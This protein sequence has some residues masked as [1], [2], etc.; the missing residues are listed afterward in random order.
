MKKH[1]KLTAFI[2][3]LANL[4][5]SAFTAQAQNCNVTMQ[6]LNS[7]NQQVTSIDPCSNNNLELR[8]GNYPPSYNYLGGFEITFPQNLFDITGSFSILFGSNP[9][10]IGISGNNQ[11]ITYTWPN[12]GYVLPTLP[13]TMSFPLTTCCTPTGI[14]NISINFNAVYH[15]PLNPN[16][17]TVNCSINPLTLPV[18]H[19]NLVANVV[20]TGQSGNVFYGG[21]DGMVVYKLINNGTGSINTESIDVTSIM[22][23][24]GNFIGIPTFHFTDTYTTGMPCSSLPPA[25]TPVLNGGLQSVINTSVSNGPLSIT[26]GHPIYF[27][28]CLTANCTNGASGGFDIGFSWGCANAGCTASCLSYIPVVFNYQVINIGTPTLEVTL[29]FTSSFPST[30]AI[31]PPLLYPM[32]ADAD[33]FCSS[34]G[35][36]SVDGKT[37]IAIK[38]KNNSTVYPSYPGVNNLSNLKIYL[39]ITKLWGSIDPNDPVYISDQNGNGYAELPANALQ[40]YT[41]MPTSPSNLS[42]YWELD[43]SSFSD[44]GMTYHNYNATNSLQVLNGDH[45]LDDLKEGDY[46]ILYFT[47]TYNNT[48]SGNGIGS[49]FDYGNFNG[50]IRSYEHFENQCNNLPQTVFDPEHVHY[51]GSA[52]RLG[53]EE[54]DYTMISDV[55]PLNNLTPATAHHL[56]IS[57][58]FA[59]L[60]NNKTYEF[61]CPTPQL[62]IRVDLPFAYHYVL[63]TVQPFTVLLD[64]KSPTS[65]NVPGAPAENI[66]VQVTPTVTEI[67][68]DCLNSI[69]GHLDITF[70]LPAS[71]IN[72][73]AYLMMP[74]PI[75]NNYIDL[76]LTVDCS[77]PCRYHPVPPYSPHFENYH[78]EY[79]FDCGSTCDAG[80]RIDHL[81][82]GDAQTIH[83]CPGDC[84]AAAFNV[85]PDGFTL[86]RNVAGKVNVD[87]PNIPSVQ[88]TSSNIMSGTSPAVTS[89]STTEKS[90][91]YP[92]DLVK[93]TAHTVFGGNPSDYSGT[94]NS[95]FIALMLFHDNV[96]ANYEDAVFSPVGG[97]YTITAHFNSD[98]E[99]SIQ[100]SYSLTQQ[101]YYHSIFPATTSYT[102]STMWSNALTSTL[103]PSAQLNNQDEYFFRVTDPA[104]NYM[105]NYTPPV[106]ETLKYFK[107]DFNIDLRVRYNS[108]SSSSSL[109][110]NYPTGLTHLGPITASLVGQGGAPSNFQ[111]SCDKYLSLFN[112]LRPTSTVNFD[113][114]VSFNC[115]S[116]WLNFTFSRDVPRSGGFNTTDDF[117]TEFRPYSE[118]TGDFDIYI[119]QD[120]H[121]VSAGVANVQVSISPDIYDAGGINNFAQGSP[122]ATVSTTASTVTLG[123]AD[124]TTSIPPPINGINYDKI[125]VHPVNGWPLVDGKRWLNSGSLV[126]PSLAVSVQAKPNCD[127]NATEHVYFN[128]NY[129]EEIEDVVT[130]DQNTVNAQNIGNDGN[131]N[132]LNHVAPNYQLVSNNTPIITSLSCNEITATFDLVAN[133]VPVTQPYIVFDLPQTGPFAIVGI[134]VSGG[135]ASITL[136]PTQLIINAPGYFGSTVLHD[137]YIFNPT[138]L[139]GSTAYT[140]TMHARYYCQGNIPPSLVTLPF[141]FLYSCDAVYTPTPQQDPINGCL[142]VA[143]QLSFQISPDIIPVVDITGPLQICPGIQPDLW[144]VAGNNATNDI[145]YSPLTYNW[146]PIPDFNPPT[147]LGSTDN[148]NYIQGG[149]TAAT[150]YGVMVTNAFGCPGSAIANMTVIDPPIPTITT[151]P[152]CDY[153]SWTTYNITWNNGM[154]GSYV[155]SLLVDPLLGTVNMNTTFPNSFQIMWTAAAAA[156]GANITIQGTSPCVFSYD[157]PVQPCCN[158]GVSPDFINGTA[159]EIQSAINPGFNMISGPQTLYIHGNLDIDQNITFNNCIIKMGAGAKINV[160]PGNQLEL[161]ESYI[162][163]CDMM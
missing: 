50:E 119:P 15:D 148:L 77:D 108:N 41:T 39:G 74:E 120:Y 31:S 56:Q 14:N 157:F 109:H 124:Y 45:H 141:A 163:G 158:D 95:Q 136:A 133:D 130:G 113:G 37:L 161:D 63:G 135:G 80:G 127:V 46:F 43:F 26:P 102:P 89:L 82:S 110:A 60:W 156:T 79:S 88:Y 146:Y 48:T 49:Y 55:I 122:L 69:P 20:S 64:E 140:F 25:V 94:S 91:S 150:S 1:I 29:G 125:S 114:P 85:A 115:G 137:V 53:Y 30:E 90:Y 12:N 143:D 47:L 61:N 106:G 86:E 59:Q 139:P 128:A 75:S 98:N 147:T 100:P 116:Q 134:N 4:L 92:G 153:S 104:I 3:L 118:L 33:Y 51:E 78:I 159:S 65:N 87:Y 62:K 7:N 72:N 18:N 144:A 121:S 58:N 9:P 117:V 162:S 129:K 5:H 152:V 68:E 149:V 76:Q 81:N 123:P 71:I 142:I 34:G 145:C 112:I 97:T 155:P 13:V 17:T 28:T 22:N 40:P 131:E 73:F 38:Y 21:Q 8:V 103:L 35:G 11:T 105:A 96:W 93:V 101:D 24:N 6:L 99:E 66:S 111:F 23:A 42:D 16:Q 132:A 36:S 138:T 57:P 2:F 154:Q 27:I 52:S 10:I 83:H 160:L 107:I 32:A 67:F 126:N 151:A 19:P 54:T 44:L 84:G 70:G